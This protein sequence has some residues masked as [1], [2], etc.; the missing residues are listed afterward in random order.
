MKKKI[1]NFK[2][3]C[4]CS[5]TDSINAH[6]FVVSCAGGEGGKKRPPRAWL[7]IWDLTVSY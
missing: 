5:S 1:S 7:R 3:K 4:Q 2:S 6:G